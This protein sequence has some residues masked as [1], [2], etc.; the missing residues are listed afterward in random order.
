M[1]KSD[2]LE[3]AVIKHVLG[4]PDYVRPATVYIALS[5]A[6][7]TDDGTG[8]TEPAG[9]GYARVSYA[10]GTGAWTDATAAGTTKLTNT[11]KITFPTA[12]ADWA[13][14]VN[15]THFAIM[16]AATGGNMLYYGPL[17]TGKPV[18]NGD[19]AEFAAGALAVTED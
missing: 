15:L 5:T 10:N 6:D 7:P 3:G 2:Y 16:D 11:N 19:T 18:L 4:G 9:G 1:S 13:S 8:L 12:T 14:G 17:S